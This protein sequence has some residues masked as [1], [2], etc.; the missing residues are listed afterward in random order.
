MRV[1]EILAVKCGCAMPMFV[2]Y[3]SWS[4][5]VEFCMVTIAP[6]K[7]KYVVYDFLVGRAGVEPAANGLKVLA[8]LF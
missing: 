4:Y 6:L 8:R 3:E 2:R 1:K 7:M 5:W